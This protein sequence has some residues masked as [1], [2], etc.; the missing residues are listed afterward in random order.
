MLL[1]AALDGALRP[2]HGARFASKLLFEPIGATSP[3]WERDGKGLPIFASHLWATA[4]DFARVGLLMLNDGC[5]K[6]RRS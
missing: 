2:E 6:D 5:W 3:V 1:G 4:R